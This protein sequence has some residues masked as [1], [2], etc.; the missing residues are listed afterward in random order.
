[1]GLLGGYEGGFGVR[2][3]RGGEA[4]GT[5]GQARGIRWVPQ[6]IEQVEWFRDREGDVKGAGTM[7]C[8]FSQS[9]IQLPPRRCGRRCRWREQSVMGSKRSDGPFRSSVARVMSLGIEIEVELSVI[10]V[11]HPQTTF[12][13]KST[14][15]RV[16]GNDDPDQWKYGGQKPCGKSLPESVENHCPSLC[17]STDRRRRRLVNATK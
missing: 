7:T 2:T 12:Q 5:Q 1:M 8:D 3:G 17:I 10:E 14:E 16:C 6:S 4:A 11:I 13:W 15:F 9:A